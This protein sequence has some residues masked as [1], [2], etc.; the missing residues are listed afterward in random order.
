MRKHYNEWMAESIKQLT[1]TGKIKRPSYETVVNWINTSWNAVDVGLIQRSFKCCGIS[2]D[3]NES[4]DELIFDYES[5]ET[6]NEI[7]YNVEFLDNN[8]NNEENNIEEIDLSN[9]FNYY[10]ENETN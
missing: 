5:L 9:D 4:E 7:S 2:N 3:R 10:D 6:S 8:D 1:P